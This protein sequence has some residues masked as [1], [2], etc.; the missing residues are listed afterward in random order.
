M[1]FDPI[2]LG[3]AAVALGGVSAASSI[4]QGRQQKKAYQAQKR[5]ADIENVRSVREQIR[6]ARI[7][8]ANILNQG[9]TGGTMGSS[10][11]QGGIASVGSQLA[12]N[13]SYMQDIAEQN[14]A[15]NDAMIGASNAGIVGAVAGTIGGAALG[16]A[17]GWQQVGKKLTGATA[18]V[19]TN[20]QG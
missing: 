6:Q 18:P 20:T 7:A 5:R 8:Q 3:I 16:M 12:G 14:A 2:T 9:A 17:G 15:Y 10:G 19:N 13:L 1:G 11:V 4:E